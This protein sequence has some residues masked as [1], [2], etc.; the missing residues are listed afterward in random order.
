MLFLSS[1]LLLAA[2]SVECFPPG[3]VTG[4]RQIRLGQCRDPN[5]PAPP[6]DRPPTTAE[7]QRAKEAF[8]LIAFDGPSARWRFE[9]VKGGELVCGL[10]NSKNRMG[11]YVGWTPFIFNLRDGSFDTY[12]ED[13]SWLYTAL[14]H[15]RLDSS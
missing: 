13:D 9:V 12:S 6:P 2:N 7:Q 10:V 11:G 5:A 4:R 8:D 3:T 1:L 15:D 14:C